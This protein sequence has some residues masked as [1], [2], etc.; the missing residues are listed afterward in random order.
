MNEAPTFRSEFAI[1]SRP[2]FLF[3]CRLLRTE[4]QSR[5]PGPTTRPAS[6]LPGALAR[7]PSLAATARS[8]GRETRV[9]NRTARHLPASLARGHLAP[10]LTSRAEGGD[11]EDGR[12][13]LTMLESLINLVSSSSWTYAV[14]LAVAALDAIIPL[15]PSE[16]TAIAAGVL[17]AA[18]ALSIELVIVAAAAGAFAG[19]TGSYFIGRELG[20]RV[21]PR[22][23]SGEKAR[24]RLGRAEGILATRG[25]YVIIFSRF[26]PGGRTAVMLT[27]GLTRMAWVRFLRFAAVA[28]AV[29]ASYA[30]LLGYIGGRAFEE[31]PWQG[32][33]LALGL[34]GA[35]GIALE[36]RRRRGRA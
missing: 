10:M 33:L 30:A 25:G 11:R 26:V 23:F 19:D 20:G 21:T 3:A 27:A 18:G 4:G 13:T 22:L 28:A 1:E 15:L 6:F 12:T 17:A 32:L 35:L 14:L 24:A 9:A 36:L 29:W 7:M 5:R 34:A 2:T 31:H 8:V 16:T